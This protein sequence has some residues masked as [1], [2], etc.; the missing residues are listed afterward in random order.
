MFTSCLN[1]F[2]NALICYIALRESGL[3]HLQAVDVLDNES[4]FGGDDGASSVDGNTLE[5]VCK[6]LGMVLERCH[7]SPDSL[8]PVT[9]LS[10]H[11]SPQVWEGRPDN[12]ADLTRQLSKLHL[13]TNVDPSLD[14]HT[15]ALEKAMS[16]YYTDR[17]TPFLGE[18]ANAVIDLPTSSRNKIKTKHMSYY[19]VTGKQIGR[20]HV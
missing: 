15:K 10:R 7:V 6:V 9:F 3:D 14:T 8:Q 5:K 1:T 18:W 20:A 4:L 11:Y 13:T 12:A 16:I 2:A 17:N 19:I